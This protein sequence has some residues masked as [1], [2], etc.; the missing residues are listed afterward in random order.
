MTRARV[1]F[2]NLDP[3]LFQ[4]EW[5]IR[6]LST[7]K[8]AKGFDLFMSKVMEYGMERYYSVENIA[9]NIEIS[10]QQCPQIYDMLRIAAD[11]LSVP[12]PKLYVDM[13]PVPNAYTFGHK[14]PFITIHHSLI[15]LLDDDELFFVIAHEVGHIKCNHVLFSM[16]AQNLQA[17]IQIIGQ[18]TLGL[19]T[20][21]GQGLYLMF[22]DW[23]RKAELSA[24]RAGLLVIQDLNVGIRVLMKLAG[25]FSPKILNQ[26]NINTFLA[27]AKQYY[28]LDKDTLTKV[29][30]LVQTA[31]TDHPWPVVRAAELKNWHDDGEYSRILQAYG[32]ASSSNICKNC[33]TTV[34]SSLRFC[35]ECGAELEL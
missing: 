25:G 11:T 5:D 9:S 27:Q 12:V 23:M 6:A 17:L 31:Y 32:V 14:N 3:M 16:V 13:N 33:G 8:Q 26:L 4:H 15:D 22:L 2:I 24:D 29:Y 7:L 18:A 35:Q 10:D 30:R 19:G 20:L 1:K 34:K 28:S 21:L